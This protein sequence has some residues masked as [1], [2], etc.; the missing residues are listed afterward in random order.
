MGPYRLL[1]FIGGDTELTLSPERKEKD[2]YLCIIESKFYP[3]L[4]IIEIDEII[5]ENGRINAR[6]LGR[7]WGFS[8]TIVIGSVG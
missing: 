1:V 3:V 8:E 6:C 2:L 7:G 5:P 4:N